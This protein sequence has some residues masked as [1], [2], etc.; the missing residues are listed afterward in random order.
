MSSISVLQLSLISKSDS[1][2][3]CIDNRAW[4]TLLEGAST[5]SMHK[6]SKLFRDNGVPPVEDWCDEE[7]I[8]TCF[9][10]F[11]VTLLG[12]SHPI[13]CLTLSLT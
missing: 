1:S 8:F 7:T 3:S 4:E 10:A 12:D 6:T 11:I 5:P 13:G 2:D 9:I